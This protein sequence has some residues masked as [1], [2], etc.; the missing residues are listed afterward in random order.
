MSLVGGS[1]LLLHSESQLSTPQILTDILLH[2]ITILQSIPKSLLS[3]ISA[4]IATGIG[5]LY[6]AV[7]RLLGY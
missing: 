4:A 6:G 7:L 2:I 1:E 3:E 5:P